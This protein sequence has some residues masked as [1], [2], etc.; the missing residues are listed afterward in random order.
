[1]HIQRIQ[2]GGTADDGYRAAVVGLTNQRGK[3]GRVDSRRHRHQSEITTELVDLGE[4]SQQEVSVQAALMHLVKNDGGS[5]V[6]PGV[7]QQAAEQDPRR[8]KFDEC[9]RSGVA[10]TP[11]GI[12]DF[13]ANAAAV[14]RCKPPGRRARGNPARLCDNNARLCGG[15][16]CLGADQVRDQRR[17]QCGFSGA[18]RCLDNGC[19][20]VTGGIF[21]LQGGSQF[22]KRLREDQARADRFQVKGLGAAERFRLR[23]GGGCHRSIVPVSGW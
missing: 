2:R 4:Y 5:A 23:S 17:Y 21:Q 7:R 8:H 13:A 10:L 18:R 11:H 3:A 9:F 22:R 16:G 20:P 19:S 6:Q 12:A 15:P 1:M 14:Q